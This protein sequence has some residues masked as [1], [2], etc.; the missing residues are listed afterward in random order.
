MK[1]SFTTQYNF[2]KWLFILFDKKLKF[3]L[4]SNKHL[5]QNLRPTENVE[6]KLTIIKNTKVKSTYKQYL[7]KEQTLI[8]LKKK[9][10]QSKM[11]TRQ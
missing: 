11:Y 10:T 6:N 2:P 5:T 8:E 3:I 7:H 4:H 1:P 9:F